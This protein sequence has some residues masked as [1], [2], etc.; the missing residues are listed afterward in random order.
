MDDETRHGRCIDLGT[1]DD[2]WAVV[3]MSSDLGAALD[4]GDGDNSSGFVLRCALA[5]STAVDMRLI[6]AL[7]R[8]ALAVK[9]AGG[10]LL[11]SDPSASL[12]ELV[13]FVGLA[14]CLLRSDGGE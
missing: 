7:A 9:Q 12:S 8:L 5:A 2:L 4:T 13:R 11:V 14:A 3:R 10:T 6:D 1:L